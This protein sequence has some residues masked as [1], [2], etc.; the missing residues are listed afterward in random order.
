MPRHIAAKYGG[1][2]MDSL[3]DLLNV[4]AVDVCTPRNIWGRCWQPAVA[5]K[6]VVREKP[7]ARHLLMQKP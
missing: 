4:D 5:G 1:R 3:E 7:L 6:H 2:A